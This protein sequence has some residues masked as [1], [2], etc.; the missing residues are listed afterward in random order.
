MQRLLT[1][2]PG[3]DGGIMWSAAVQTPDNHDRMVFV[4]GNWD[5]AE[6]LVQISPTCTVWFDYETLDS[7]GFLEMEVPVG[8]FVRVG[9]VNPGP[10]TRISAAYV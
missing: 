5:G 9:V 4:W 7:D 3:F 2:N 8:V 1:E 6:S 10:D